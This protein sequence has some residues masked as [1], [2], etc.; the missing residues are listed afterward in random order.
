MAGDGAADGSEDAVAGFVACE[1]AGCTAGGGAEET[2][3]A[4]LRL[5]DVVGLV[6]LVVVVA[7]LLTV[8]V[9]ARA[10]VVVI[11]WLLVL[12]VL[13]VASVLLV[14]LIVVA[15]VWGRLVGFV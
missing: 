3:L 10:L 5:A 6:V 2:S 7:R 12:V 4:I 13:V 9:L 8:V 11:V 14:A 1:A 15:H